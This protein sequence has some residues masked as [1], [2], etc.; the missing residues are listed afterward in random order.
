VRR[1]FST[2]DSDLFFGDALNAK[3]LFFSRLQQMTKYF[4]MREYE[5]ISTGI[6]LCCDS[7]FAHK[8]D[9]LFLNSLKGFWKSL[10]EISQL[11]LQL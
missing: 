1:A 7:A 11:W 10:A 3:Q 2:L 6:S 9:F 4:V 5:I 8:K